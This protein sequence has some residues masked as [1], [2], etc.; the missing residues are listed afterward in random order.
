MLLSV[1]AGLM[2]RPRSSRRLRLRL[3]QFARSID[4]NLNFGVVGAVLLVLICHATSFSAWIGQRLAVSP[5]PFYAA[6]KPE[7]VRARFVDNGMTASSLALSLEISA[8]VSFANRRVPLVV[9]SGADVGAATSGCV[10]LYCRSYQ[11]SR[12]VRILDLSLYSSSSSSLS[13]I[14]TV[15]LAAFVLFPLG[16]VSPGP[17]Q[18][19]YNATGSRGHEFF[20]TRIVPSPRLS[21]GRRL[22]RACT[23]PLLTS[24]TYAGRQGRY[25]DVCYQLSLS[26]PLFLGLVRAAPRRCEWREGRRVDGYDIE[27]VVVSVC[28][29]GG[30]VRTKWFRKGRE[31]RGAPLTCGVRVSRD[32]EV[33]GALGGIHRRRSGLTLSH[34]VC[35][36]IAQRGRKGRTHLMVQIVGGDHAH[37]DVAVRAF[38]RRVCSTVILTRH[39]LVAG[40]SGGD[41][42]HIYFSF[43]RRSGRQGERGG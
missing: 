2:S 1:T 32:C 22:A 42:C 13:T 30:G 39:G 20:R 38:S 25:E 19:F 26:P 5:S 23:G 36:R 9:T 41:R 18:L 10:E 12:G 34:G 14:T 37:L 6:T 21:I 27:R 35:M 40:T 43:R 15:S 17:S 3:G 29:V 33:R 4:D 7:H 16:P 31:G 24:L 11:R 28:R 8:R